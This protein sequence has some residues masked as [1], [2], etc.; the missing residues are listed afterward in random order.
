[1]D[2]KHYLYHFA[3]LNTAKHKG[4]PAPH[5]AVL[6][7]AVMSLIE[8]GSISTPEIELTDELVDEFKKI[9]TEKL[10]VSCPFSCDI[11]KPYFHMQHEPFWRLLEHEENY[12]IVA[13]ELGL[14]TEEKKTM[15]K[16]YTVSAMREKFLCAKIDS[17]LYNIIRSN[18]DDRKELENLLIS[19]YLTYEPP[20]N[21]RHGIAAIIGTAL[22]M[23]A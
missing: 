23:V 18:A 8:R 13:E 17:E 22:L 12:W 5:K 7:L 3:H 15:A 19:K 11:S 16:G 4:K 6:L 2:I 14:Y 1:M 20:L 21:K 10:P 9:W